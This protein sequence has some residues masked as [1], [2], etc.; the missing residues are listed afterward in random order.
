MDDALAQRILDAVAAIPPGRVATYGDVAAEAGGNSPRFA[1][2]VLSNLA[3]DD[4]PWHR[5]LPAHGRP[6]PRLADRQLDRL[7]AEG[8]PAVDGR[9]PMGRYRIGAANRR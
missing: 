5:V 2:W 6:V 7:A 1:G 3:E 8:V 4:L 9:V